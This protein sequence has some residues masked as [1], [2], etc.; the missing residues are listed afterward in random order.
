VLLAHLE[1]P[2]DGVVEA[3]LDAVGHGGMPCGGSWV[4][5][6]RCGE[7][8]GPLPERVLAAALL[9][10]GRTEHPEAPGEVRRAWEQGLVDARAAHLALAEAVSPE[11]REAAEAHLR[12]PVAAPA[13]AMH[14]A[15]TRHPWLMAVLEPLSS[16]ASAR[17]WPATPASACG[18]GH[19]LT[20]PGALGAW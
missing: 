2:D 15:V 3:A 9:A 20:L 4:R 19:V 1:H 11:L 8:R 18:G 10:L 16:S 14:L 12:D 7:R 5:R 17:C 6:W 13:A